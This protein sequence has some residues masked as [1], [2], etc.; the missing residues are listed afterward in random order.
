MNIGSNIGQYRILRK[1]GAGGMGTVYLAEHILLGRRAAIKT[2]LPRLSVQREIVE[3]FFDEARATSAIAHPGVVQIF[4]FGYHVDGTAYIVMELL[5]GEALSARLGRLGTLPIGDALRIAR[6]VA[7]SL[8][9]AHAK[10]IVHRDLKPENVFLIQ[11]REALGGERAKI[12]DFGIC[13]LGDRDATVTQSG[14][15]IGTPV[16]MSP[17]QCRGAGGIDHRSDIYA[18]G[19]VLFHMLTGR[20]PFECDGAGEFIVAHMREAPP[21]P[22]SYAAEIPEL[23][24]ELLLRCLAKSPDD[25]FASMVALQAEIDHV[26]EQLG[27]SRSTISAPPPTVRLGDGFKSAYN[28]NL[29]S[30]V[31]T[32][33]TPPGDAEPPR[34]P[35]ETSPIVVA[36]GVRVRPPAALAILLFGV[37]GALI[38]TRLALDGDEAIAEPSSPA[39]VVEPAPMPDPTEEMLL[40]GLAELLVVPQRTE[41][42]PTIQRPP[43]RAQKAPKKSVK[44]PVSKRRT[45]R[46]AVPKKQAAPIEDLYDT[47]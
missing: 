32:Q 21:V 45:P 4:D 23:V 2:L 30:G 3:R 40:P 38:A 18:L 7:G 34:R 26:I 43:P 17:E 39:I 25:R 13:K 41:V 27:I 44:K 35:L 1:L 12:L 36:S 20:P 37:I 16:Y 11:D 5:E 47:R 33:D 9:A 14:A 29:G 10:A 28:G 46:R 8:E 6:Q 15:L 42:E 24:D 19:C 31:P 22:S